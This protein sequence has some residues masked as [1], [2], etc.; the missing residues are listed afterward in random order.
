MWIHGVYQISNL[1]R[2]R[3]VT[4]SNTTDAMHVLKPYEDKL[5]GYMLVGLRSRDGVRRT[6]LLH[7]VVARVWHGHPRRKEVNHKNGIRGD[8]RASNLEYVTHSE[9]I[10]DAV[11]RMRKNGW[12]HPAEVLTARNIRSIRKRLARGELQSRVA[13]FYG[14]HKGTIHYIA[15]GTTWRHVS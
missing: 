4:A 13:R 5:T 2:I 9:N 6:H 11:K 7:R 8:C 10:Q 15:N 14:V 12:S 1:G 3:R